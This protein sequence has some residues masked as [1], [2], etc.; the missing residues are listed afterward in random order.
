MAF[1]SLCSQS[2]EFY[3][4]PLEAQLER[5]QALGALA[6]GDFIVTRHSNIAG[7]QVVFHLL[8]DGSVAPEKT[9]L[10]QEGL[11]NILT[12]CAEFDILTLALPTLLMPFE[13]APLLPESQALRFAD[14]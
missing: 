12:V 4:D 10:L 3:F 11:K 14:G 6:V 9:T 7:T 2:T 13:L 1:R 5:T 8:H